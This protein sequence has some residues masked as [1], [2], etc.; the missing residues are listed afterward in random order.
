MLLKGNQW[1][2]INGLEVSEAFLARSHPSQAPRAPY[3]I[4][5]SLLRP[6]VEASLN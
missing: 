6:G 2:V 5:R 1:S 4:Q 3:N